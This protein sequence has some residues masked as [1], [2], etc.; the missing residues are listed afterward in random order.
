M[1][2]AVCARA[3]HCLSAACA[4][5]LVPPVQP[6]PQQRAVGRLIR[7]GQPTEPKASTG[8]TPRQAGLALFAPLPLVLH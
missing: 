8:L 7:H 6:P 3:V 2:I 5:A 4:A 1:Q